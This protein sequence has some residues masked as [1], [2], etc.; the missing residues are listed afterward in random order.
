MVEM[1]LNAGQEIDSVKDCKYNFSVTL[2]KKKPEY[3]ANPVNY[4]FGI[5]FVLL[6]SM[7]KNCQS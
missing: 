5:Q 2:V 4:P 1:L 3:R 7:P 6:L